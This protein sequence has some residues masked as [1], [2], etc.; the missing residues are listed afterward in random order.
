[1]TV[2]AMTVT[3]FEIVSGMSTTSAWICWRSVVDRLM[4]SPVWTR[5]WYPKCSRCVWAKIWSRSRT[6]TRRDSRNAQ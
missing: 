1:M 5:S 4:R 6:S 2:T 3:K